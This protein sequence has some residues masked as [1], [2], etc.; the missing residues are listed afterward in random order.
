MCLSFGHNKDGTI[1][2]SYGSY[3]CYSEITVLKHFL[4]FGSLQ[5]VTENVP[6]STCDLLC[7]PGTGDQSLKM[8]RLRPLS[9]NSVF[10]FLF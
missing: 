6:V 5:K 7:S 2:H 4:I 10:S 1:Q 3:G 9:V 8:T